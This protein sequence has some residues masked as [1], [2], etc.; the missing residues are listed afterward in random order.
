MKPWSSLT[1]GRPYRAVIFDVDGTLY[2][3]RRLRAL[4]AWELLRYYW[5]RWNRWGEV[6]IL[7]LY[8]RNREAGRF[9]DHLETEQYSAVARRCGVPERSVRRIVE[10]WMLRAPLSHLF[11]CRDRRLQKLIFSLR[12]RGTAVFAY[13]DYPAAEKLKA[14]KIPVD[15]CFCATDREIMRLKPDPRGLRVILRETGFSASECLMVGDRCDRDGEAADGAGMDYL[16]LPPG[17]S[18][19]RA[20]EFLERTFAQ[21]LNSS[22][23]EG[24][25]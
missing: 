15:R 19:K 23:T 25:N 11:S 14:L 22:E 18:R 5:F 1:A 6:R 4:M 3:G 8:R 20:V 10:R 9:S 21:N 13:S 7:A 2:S 24:S 17:R 12:G 16:I